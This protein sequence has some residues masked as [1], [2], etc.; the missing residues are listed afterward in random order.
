[1]SCM[2][3]V[4]WLLTFASL[5]RR[6]GARGAF[7]RSSR[8]LG[9]PSTEGRN[10]PAASGDRVQRLPEILAGLTD[11]LGDRARSGIIEI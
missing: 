7:S 10:I 9:L 2:A 1:M 11:P 4:M 5:Q 3:V 8:V 6:D